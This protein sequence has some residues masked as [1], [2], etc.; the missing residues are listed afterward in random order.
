MAVCVVCLLCA[1]HLPCKEHVVGQIVHPIRQ[2]ISSMLQESPSSHGHELNA[3][4]KRHTAIRRIE[5]IEHDPGRYFVKQLFKKY[6]N[7]ADM[8]MTLAG[9]ENMLDQLGLVKYLQ[10]RN[11]TTEVN[12]ASTNE[13]V[14]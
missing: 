14:T 5:E 11:P 8:T 13:T 12:A 9:F 4:V 3:R 10:E 6:G 7:E 1:D 2:D